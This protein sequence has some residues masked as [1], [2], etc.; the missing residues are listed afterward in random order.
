[1]EVEESWDFL[2]KGRAV[3]WWLSELHGHVFCIIGGDGGGCHCYR[4]TLRRGGDG[5]SNDT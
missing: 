3:K 4:P 1:M 5:A 2:K